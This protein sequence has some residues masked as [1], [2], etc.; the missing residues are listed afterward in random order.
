LLFGRGEF[1][2]GERMHWRVVFG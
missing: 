1:N 2:F